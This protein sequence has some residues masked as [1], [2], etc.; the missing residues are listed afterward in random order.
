MVIKEANAAAFEALFQRDAGILFADS[1]SAVSGCETADSILA[2][3][4]QRH[5][6][7]AYP[8]ECRVNPSRVANYIFSG[9]NRS[10]PTLQRYSRRLQLFLSN[11]RL[12]YP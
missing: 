9:N 1:R 7:E 4:K 3:K 11:C 8:P 6:T 5:S 2:R 10:P 12:Q